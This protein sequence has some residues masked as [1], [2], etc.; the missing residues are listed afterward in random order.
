MGDRK[1]VKNKVAESQ[2]VA[3]RLWPGNNEERKLK[4]FGATNMAAH[5]AQT[6]Y[7]NVPHI[8]YGETGTAVCLLVW[9]NET[10]PARWWALA[11]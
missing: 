5:T 2:S 9:F 6:D 4:K 3:K 10:V 11:F 8:V 1:T 7:Q